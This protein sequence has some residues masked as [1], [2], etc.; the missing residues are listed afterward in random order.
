MALMC[1][2][3]KKKVTRY[4]VSAYQIISRAWFKCLM[5]VRW[6]KSKT[7]KLNL[8]VGAGIEMGPNR[9]NE[10]KTSLVKVIFEFD[11]L[12][13]YF[14]F[15][16]IMLSS[17]LLTHCLMIG[18]MFSEILIN[19]YNYVVQVTW[20][21]YIDKHARLNINDS[22]EVREGEGRGGGGGGRAS[23]LMPFEN[24][25]DYIMTFSELTVVC[26]YTKERL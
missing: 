15:L 7:K 8:S 22:R 13:A 10:K 21:T 12:V 11:F 4:D 18:D 16:Q 20:S 24:Q 19:G 2:L 17:L 5:T 23:K 9:I 6:T 14:Q 25:G 1:Y 26:K 3:I